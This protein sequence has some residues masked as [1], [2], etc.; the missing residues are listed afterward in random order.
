M[1]FLDFIISAQF[2]YEMFNYYYNYYSFYTMTQISEEYQYLGFGGS[3][4]V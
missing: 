2:P 1:G 4:M 3:F